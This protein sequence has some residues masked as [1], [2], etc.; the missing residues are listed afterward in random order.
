MNRSILSLALTAVLCVSC[1]PTR[2]VTTSPYGTQTQYSTV[3][4][5]PRT[6]TTTTTQVYAS[7]YDISLQLDLQAVAAAFA[8][9]ESVR[10]FEELLNSSSYM[11]SN[12]DLNGDGYIDYLRVLETVDG[13]DH[14]FLIQAVLAED[15]YQDVATLVVE[16]PA[17]TTCYVE[18]IG[19]PYIYGPNYIVRPSFIARPPLFAHMSRA[20][21]T[22]WRS[23]WHWGSFPASYKQ[24]KPQH[25]NHYQAYVKTFMS[26]HKYCNKVYYPETPHYSNYSRVT[27]KEQRSDYSRQ[28][29]E[30]SFSSR[31][32]S[33]VQKNGNAPKAESGSRKE[34]NAR[35][36][37]ERHEASKTTT[38]VTT[39]GRSSKPEGQTSGTAVRKTEG[40]T[41][42]TTV[43]KTE[44]KNSGTATRKPESS[45][46]EQ[47]TAKTGGEGKTVTS[48]V[49][50]SG[51]ASTSTRSSS[52][53]HSGGNTSSSGKSGSTTRRTRK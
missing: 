35:D 52:A 37:Y 38:T 41:S 13:L 4:T 36:V 24:P 9:S 49:N 50:A 17:L 44:E 7:D 43:R 20:G 27:A 23:P 32:T 34:T 47:Q 10:E 6:H 46:K 8:Q 51:S 33:T 29:P 25:L 11:I 30:K 3:V 12:L 15:I 48:R 28:H 31:S 2:I 39:P 19:D 26:N 21:Y 22:P 53:S 16:N 5:V 45:Q 40:Q 1:F 14:V 18:I 42:G